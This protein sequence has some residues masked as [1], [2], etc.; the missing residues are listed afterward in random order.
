MLPMGAR[1]RKW[2]PR[3]YLLTYIFFNG[4]MALFIGANFIPTVEELYYHPPTDIVLDY[5]WPCMVYRYIQEEILF[6]GGPFFYKGGEWYS[7]N[8]AINVLLGL[9][10][11]ML[12]AVLCE[13]LLRRRAKARSS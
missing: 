5:G 9:A 3:F 12:V 2:L 8:L 7:R 11:S 10:I 6:E 13:I 1:A 4:T